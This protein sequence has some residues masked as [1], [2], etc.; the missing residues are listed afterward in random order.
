MLFNDV[1]YMLVM[2]ARQTFFFKR[3]P[4]GNEGDQEETNGDD[5][6]F[7]RGHSYESNQAL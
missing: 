1:L 6:D 3:N 2:Y 7:H 4:I 5:G